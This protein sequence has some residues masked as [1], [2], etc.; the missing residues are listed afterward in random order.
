[1]MQDGS[2][3]LVSSVDQKDEMDQMDET[4]NLWPFGCPGVLPTDTLMS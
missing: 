2:V 1:M 4:D 3:Y